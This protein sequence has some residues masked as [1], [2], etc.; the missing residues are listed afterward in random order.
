M[1]IRTS[2]VSN[3]SSSSFIF[4]Q[5][6]L[7]SNNKLNKI[8]DDIIKY[9]NTAIS[10]VLSVKSGTSEFSSL[11]TYLK[12]INMD[13]DLKVLSRLV[14]VNSKDELEDLLMSNLQK[15]DILDHIVWLYNVCGET[16]EEAVKNYITETVEKIMERIEVSMKNKSLSYPINA[17]KLID[18]VEVEYCQNEDSRINFIKKD[19]F[20]ATYQHEKIYIG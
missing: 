17:L 8:L 12:N 1:K 15:K 20:D 14:I 2:F 7:V 10:N 4:I 11:A 9:A 3:S 5:I 6:G 13:E 19:L 18:V 16:N